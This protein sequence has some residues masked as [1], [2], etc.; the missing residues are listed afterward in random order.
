MELK[1]FLSSK[2]KDEYWRKIILD[3]LSYWVCRMSGEPITPQKSK[4]M[5]EIADQVLAGRKP[6]KKKKKI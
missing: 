2:R 4:E 3:T 1:E 5:E 6:N